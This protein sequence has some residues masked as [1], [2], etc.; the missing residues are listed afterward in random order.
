MIILIRIVQSTEEISLNSDAN[1][2]AVLLNGFVGEI[3]IFVS[4]ATKSN[5]ME[6]TLVSTQKSSCR[7]AKDLSSVQLEGIT[8]EVDRR[9]C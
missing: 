5:A 7:S 4:H 6:I 2:V 9:G 1:S 3:L 8:T